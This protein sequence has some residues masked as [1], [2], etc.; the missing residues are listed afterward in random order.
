MPTKPVA[1][2]SNAP[3][4]KPV[5]DS[6]PRKTNDDRRHDDADDGDRRVLAAQIGRAPSWI[7]PATSIMRWLPARCGEHLAAGDDAVE[8]GDEAAGDSDIKQVHGFR[9]LPCS[10]R[11]VGAAGG[12]RPPENG[13]EFRGRLRGLQPRELATSAD[14]QRERH[15]AGEPAKADQPLA[16]REARDADRREC[17]KPNLSGSATG[18]PVAEQPDR[19]A[20]RRRGVPMRSIV[21]PSGKESVDGSSVG[22]K[23]GEQRIIVAAGRREQPRLQVVARAPR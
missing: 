1:P 9:S 19:R 15:A 6:G 18:L 20:R 22:R 12:R 8:H 5:A 2:D 3:S 23:R 21:V 13:G 7:A 16:E 4:T 17:S 10:L 11:Q 14:Q